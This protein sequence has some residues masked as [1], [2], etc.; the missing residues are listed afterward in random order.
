[1]YV[2]DGTVNSEKTRNFHGVDPRL[3][4]SATFC[5]TVFKEEGFKDTFTEGTIIRIPN[6]R[7]QFRDCELELKWS[8]RVTQKQSDDGWKEKEFSILDP[9]DPQAKEIE[10]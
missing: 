9:S 1:M 8:N 4:P 10:K 5:L 7:C 3:P 2:A 6:V